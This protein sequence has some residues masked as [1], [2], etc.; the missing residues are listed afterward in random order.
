MFDKTKL[1]I[2][3]ACWLC[4]VLCIVSAVGSVR[5]GEA[6]SPAVSI[7]NAGFEEPAP[8]GGVPGWRQTYGQGVAAAVYGISDAVKFDGSSSLRI[9]DGTA[10]AALGVES[11]TFPVAPGTG[12]NASA[13][14]L[15]ERSVIAIYM[16]FY[17]A[18]GIR[19]GFAYQ[20]VSATGS[21]WV[22]GEAFG[23]APQD[24]VS[25]A[26]MLY[27]SAGGLGA[28]YVDDVQVEVRQMGT[29]EN[30]GSPLLSVINNGSAIG[31]DGQGHDVIYS[32]IKGG[33]DSTVFVMIDPVTAEV[34]KSIG[35]PG[36]NGA[37]AVLAA[38]DGTVYV[39][40][41]HNGRLY[42]HIPGSNTLDDLGRLGQETHVFDLVEGKDD[43]IYAGTY[44]NAHVYEYDPATS[45]IRDIGRIDPAEHYVRS[46]AYNPETDTL[47][48]GAGGQTARLYAI[49]AATGAKR[50]LLAGLLPQHYADY[51]FPYSM[52]YG[53]GKLLVKMNKPDHLLVIDTATETVDYFDPDGGIGLGSSKVVTMQ[54]DQQHIYFGGYQLRSYNADTGAIASEFADPAM[55][56]F[57]FQDA[58]FVQ[59]N[60]PDWPGYTMLA[61]GDG[62]QIMRFNPTTKQ[63]SLQRV[64]N[65]GAP[66]L[67]RSLHGTPD[68]KVYAGAYMM[69]FGG[70]DP[71]TG[72][73]LQNREFGQAETIASLGD[74]VYV[75]IYGNARIFRYDPSS[76]WTSGSNPRMLFELVGDGQDRP[77]A[78]AGVESLGKLYIG[79]VPGYGSL[80]GALTVY[81]I[82]TKQR[83]VFRNIVPNQSV[84]SVVYKDG[85]IYGGTTVY[86]GLGT[87]GPTETSGKLFVFDTATNTKVFEMAPAPGR[88]AVSG[89]LAGP[90]G[91]IWG[92]AEDYIFKFDPVT[93]QIVY[94]QAKLGRYGASQTVWADAFLQIGTD[95]NVYGTQVGKRFFMIKPD[96]MEFV[97]IK[98]G[99]GNYLTQDLYGNFYMSN[100]ADLWK[101]T[102]PADEGTISGILKRASLAGQISQP[103]Q[104]QL[105][106][107]LRQA[108][109]HHEE[110]RDEQAV[111]H[112]RDFL[113]HLHNKAFESSVMP[114][115]KWPL[116]QQI[117]TL[118]TEWEK[119]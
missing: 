17:N 114:E 41:Y 85:F 64:M 5:I 88:K 2:V 69:G 91:L 53:L 12:Y 75:G 60:D 7:Y 13:M 119:Q 113:K 68:G 6:Y 15:V 66:T 77:F 61:S 10:S 18:A 25:G 1:R 89:L 11:D 40:T 8:G 104:A 58:K 47:Y 49:D 3:I 93:R 4:L 111:K 109:H 50:E 115:A 29:F 43:L 52:G 99:A 106:N 87:S 65:A 54:G 38:S 110:R 22:R 48:A 57:N 90:D 83:Q 62:G 100:D 79:T 31:T 39:G 45:Q 27:S 36:V 20:S 71:Q 108:V 107:S 19:V 37:W 28:G 80:S 32:V 34:K 56:A 42:R 97:V 33:N 95:G 101:Y 16:Q 78:I 117:R 76:P 92:V 30:L 59:L 86:G 46:L 118:I 116:D 21:Q 72:T 9:D 55:R 67:I 51:Q 70:Y 94:N 24:A 81:D 84:V 102:L 26:V 63:T 82:A 44:P 35:M 98:S 105:T 14:F 23:V 112:L 96:T 103:V 74:D 73:F